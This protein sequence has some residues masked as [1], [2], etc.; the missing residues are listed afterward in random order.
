LRLRILALGDSVPV[1]EH[2]LERAAEL[3]GLE[4][5]Q[6]RLDGSLPGEA[7]DAFR[8]QYE[9]YAL[10]GL[11]PSPRGDEDLRLL[12]VD[13]DIFIEGL[14]YCFGL[15]SGRRAVVSTRRLDPAYYGQP[16]D[17]ARLMQRLLKEIVHEAGHMLG[18]E[19][20]GN[21]RCVMRF[22]RDILDTDMKGPGF[23]QACRQR[24]ASRL[25]MSR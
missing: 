25:A 10:L 17:R 7:Y 5:V 14:N 22:S 24:I 13:E 15:A 4:V 11:L 23:C 16:A 21:V 20:C 6:E 8:R 18:L 19:H 12:V 2:V 1:D 9:A 3:L